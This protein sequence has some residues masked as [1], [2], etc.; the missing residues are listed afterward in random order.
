MA[1]ALMSG[2]YSC[3]QMRPFM[4][5]WVHMLI[6]MFVWVPWGPFQFAL[7]LPINFFLQ[8]FLLHEMNSN[9]STD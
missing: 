5:G 9:F 8:I 1:S 4:L 6:I 2:I 7:V 3:S